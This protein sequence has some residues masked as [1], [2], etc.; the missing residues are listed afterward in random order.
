MYDFFPPP[1]PHQ[2]EYLIFIFFRRCSLLMPFF[3]SLLWLTNIAYVDIAVK[4]LCGVDG[5]WNHLFE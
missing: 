5:E 2:C 3:I 4:M 1:H